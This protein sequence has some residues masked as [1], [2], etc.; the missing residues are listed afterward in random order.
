MVP[1]EENWSGLHYTY[2]YLFLFLEKKLC[3]KKAVCSY[4]E[5]THY[6]SFMSTKVTE[7]NNYFYIIIVYV[8]ALKHTIFRNRLTAI[9]HLW[10]NCIHI[11][12]TKFQIDRT[13]SSVTAGSL[14][15]KNNGKTDNFSKLKENNIFNAHP[16]VLLINPS[17]YCKYEEKKRLP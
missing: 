12:Q 11:T 14:N 10:P 6:L 7:F 5:C 17:K 13:W 2:Q 16:F 9:A 8:F 15:L 3:W 1:S 4:T